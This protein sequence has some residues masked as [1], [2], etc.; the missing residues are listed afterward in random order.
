MKVLFLAHVLPYPLTDGMRSTCFQILRHVSQ[1]HETTLLVLSE[2]EEDK[3]YIPE[4]S[5]W[6]PR[7]EIIHSP[8]PR[9]PFR[10]LKNVFFEKDP[11]CVRQ[12]YSP[13]YEQKLKQ[14][15]KEERFDV[16]HL[17][18]VNV[19]AYAHC[20][21]NI[22]TLFF[23][24]DSVSMQFYR[25]L[26]FEK[27][28][29]YRFYMHSQWKKMLNYEKKILPQ[30]TQTVLVSEV[31]KDWIL[32]FCPQAKISIIPAGVDC[33]YFTPEEKG[34][35][36]LGT[37]PF[38]PFSLEQPSVL[39]RG[40]M[41]FPPNRDA[42]LYFYH[43]ILPLIKKQIPNLIFYIVGKDPPRE[44]LKLHDGIHTFVTGLVP[45][46]RP[47]IAGSTVNICPLLSGSGIKNKILEAWAMEKPVV[48]TS[49]AC[50]G[51]QIEHRKNILI[52]D[53]AKTFAQ[54][55]TELIHKPELRYEIGKNGRELVKNQYSW[56]NSIS[57]F[58]EIYNKIKK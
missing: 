4:V 40:V 42:V 29:L 21:R 5:K 43:H 32:K 56:E 20:L 12:F 39:F 57:K 49:I 17:L 2:F 54:S 33:D 13:A 53:D 28:P 22:P 25:N 41:N 6:C 19:S 58:E 1:R 10:R 45:D 16:V 23:P 7:V 18:S 51:I 24:H 14:L 11:Y 30:F 34:T 47:Y 48:A 50:G 46:L 3:K 8:I 31:D 35:V 9:S 38:S 44:I 15:I 37:V 55:V 52:A 27:N 36:P 26:Q